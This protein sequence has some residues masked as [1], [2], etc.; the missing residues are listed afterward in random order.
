MVD[1]EE[2]SL[3]VEELKTKEMNEVEIKIVAISLHALVGQRNPNKI[4]KQ[5]LCQDVTLY[6]EGHKFGVDLFVLP[7]RGVDIV[8]GARWLSTLGPI[9]MDYKKLML[10]FTRGKEHLA[11][12]DDNH[13]V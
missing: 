11:F 12:M 6:L 4:R 1:D 10:S 7:L 2:D 8:L 3:P 13:K 9:V 5:G